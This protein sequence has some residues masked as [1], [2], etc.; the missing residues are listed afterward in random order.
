MIIILIFFLK[1]RK[2]C[3]HPLRK[4]KNVKK[5]DK[6]ILEDGRHCCM[7]KSKEFKETDRKI[8]EEALHHR[9]K[10]RNAVPGI[11]PALEEE[12]PGSIPRIATTSEKED[13]KSM[14]RISATSGEEDPGSM[15]G[16]SATSEE[17]DPVSMPGISAAT[18][19]QGGGPRFHN[20][21]LQRRGDGGGGRRIRVQD[22]Q[23]SVVKKEI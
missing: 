11:S 1:G 13:P 4:V 22:P 17:E 3:H 18:E 2:G 10:E 14:P 6:Q 8:P 5:T 15:H 21:D 20:R 19:E 16:I 9:G 12:D 7:R 23:K